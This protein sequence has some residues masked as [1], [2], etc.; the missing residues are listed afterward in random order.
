M[1]VVMDRIVVVAID[2]VRFV[3]IAVVDVRAVVQAPELVRVVVTEVRE[4]EGRVAEIDFERGVVASGGTRGELDR[5][6]ERVGNPP[7]R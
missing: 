5:P 2:A 7:A 6:L 1:P 4:I 3:E